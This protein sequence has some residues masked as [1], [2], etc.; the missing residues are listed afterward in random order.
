[1]KKTHFYTDLMFKTDASLLREYKNPINNADK[2]IPIEVNIHTLLKKIVI[3]PTVKDYF[4]L[5]FVDLIER[6]EIDPGIISRSEILDI[7]EDS[8]EDS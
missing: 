6:Y 2:G 1:M 8:Q 4:N 5:P 7:Q 3:S